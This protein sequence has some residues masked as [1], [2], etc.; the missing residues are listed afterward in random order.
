[1]N[2]SC[3][4]L[5]LACFCA[6]GF[7]YGVAAA[8]EDWEDH[9]ERKIRPLLAQHC[10]KCHGAKEQEGNLRLDTARG[11]S[12]GGD[13]GRVIAAGEPDASLLIKAVRQTGDL[14]MPPDG[15]L[16]NGEIADLVKWRSADGQRS[17]QIWSP[18]KSS[19][20]GRR[21]KQ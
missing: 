12:L 8:D 4:R 9:F 21:D 6:V 15:K 16:K 11:L 5:I 17:R 10:W 18:S 19:Q 20:T 14:K 1:M 7:S 2:A 3:N 13:S